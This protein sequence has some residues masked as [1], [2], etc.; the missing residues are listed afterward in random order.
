MITT[1]LFDLGGVLFTNGTKKFIKELSISHKIPEDKLREVID[2][3]IGSLY[4]ESKITR[5]NFWKKVIEI[6]HL[7]ESANTLEKK[8]IDGYEIISG[9]REIIIELSKEYKVFYLSDNV[10]E[11]VDSLNNK[12]DFIRLFKGGIFSHEAGVRKPNPKIYEFALHKSNSKPEE[13]IFIDDKPHFLE[14]AKKLGIE[15]ILFT[16]PEELRE[17]LLER[18]LI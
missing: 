15:T 5:D 4:R 6:L 2:G 8:W 13:T 9:T 1:C 17:R 18:Q 3:E 16:T 11:R 14:P 7:P 12:F 10:K